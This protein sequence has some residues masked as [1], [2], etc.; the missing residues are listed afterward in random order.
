MI[1][2]IVKKKT[3]D[4]LT[5]LFSAAALT[6]LAVVFVATLYYGRQIFVPMAL[7][8]LLS[9]VVAPPVGLLQRLRVPRA[10]AVV[11]VVLFAFAVIFGLASLI[12]AQLTQLAGDLPQY[13][14]TMQAKI[15]SVRGISGSHGTLERAAVILQHLSDE[16]DRPK[17]ADARPV[18]PP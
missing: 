1:P 18:A 8:I 15:H 14:S 9:F 2:K 11:G 6:F 5:S 4:D 7:A 16:I 3:L 10:V 13:Q 12:A 17:D